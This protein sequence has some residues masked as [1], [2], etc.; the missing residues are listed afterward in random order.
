MKTRHLQDIRTNGT[1]SN[2]FF[3]RSV[4]GLGLDNKGQ[5]IDG[6]FE[7]YLNGRGGNYFRTVNGLQ[8]S[9]SFETA[10]NFVKQGY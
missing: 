5:P 6:I 8:Y 4:K 1:R 3:G 7:C 9:I 2:A 10:F